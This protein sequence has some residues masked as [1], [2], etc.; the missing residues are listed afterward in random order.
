MALMVSGL[1]HQKKHGHSERSVAVG[2]GG[3]DTESKNPASAPMAFSQDWKP[4]R[5]FTG[6]FTARRPATEAHTD[7]PFRMTSVLLRQPCG[8]F[9]ER[10]T[11]IRARPC[12]PWFF[13]FAIHVFLPCFHVFMQ[14]EIKVRG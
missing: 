2:A 3:G 7:A 11:P 9:P 8:W 10:C 13:L 6:F 5:H 1:T 12:H 4:F 14:T